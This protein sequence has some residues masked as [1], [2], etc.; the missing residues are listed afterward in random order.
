M[1]IDVAEIKQNKYAEKFD[2]LRTYQARGSKYID[3]KESVSKNAKKV[4]D[5]WE[6][7][8]YGFKNG[9]LLPLKKND[10]KTDSGDQRSNILDTP[11]QRRFD[12]FLEQIEEE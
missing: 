1:T 4:F 3:L 9:I 6:K 8:V 5:G 12:D 11:G 2:E 10:M 7:I